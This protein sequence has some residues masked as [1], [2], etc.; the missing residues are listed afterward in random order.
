MCAWDQLLLLMKVK[1]FGHFEGQKYVVFFSW[2][3]WINTLLS[4]IWPQVV[5]WRFNRDLPQ[6]IRPI[7]ALNGLNLLHVLYCFSEWDLDHRFSVFTNK[8]SCVFIKSQSV[9]V[10]RSVWSKPESVKICPQHQLTLRTSLL[11]TDASTATAWP[12]AQVDLQGSHW[13]SHPISSQ[14]GWPICSCG[15]CPLLCHL[16]AP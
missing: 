5:Y 13:L 9:P 2:S 14:P 3:C 15:R 11:P 1:A 16:C 4:V 10:S 12:P 8:T 6:Y 7:S